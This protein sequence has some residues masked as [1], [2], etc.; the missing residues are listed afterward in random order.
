MMSDENTCKQLATLLKVETAVMLK[1]LANH[2][3]FQHIEGENNG[4]IDFVEKYGWIM[5]E[6]YCGFSCPDRFTCPLA[7]EYLPKEEKRKEPE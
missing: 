2:K 4:M 5:R 7:K 6:M 1:H 3:W